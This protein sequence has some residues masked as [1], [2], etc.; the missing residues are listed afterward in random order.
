MDGIDLTKEQE[1][2]KHYCNLKPTYIQYVTY[3]DDKVSV[4]NTE[5]KLQN[6]QISGMKVQ[7]T[8]K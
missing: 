1:S 8:E 4:A 5:D 7:Q 2:K 6:W 3:T